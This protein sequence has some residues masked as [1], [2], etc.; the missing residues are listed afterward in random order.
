MENT[1]ALF[2][3]VLRREISALLLCLLGRELLG[4]KI[5][6]LLSTIVLHPAGKAAS[7]RTEAGTRFVSVPPAARRGAPRSCSPPAPASPALCSCLCSP[8]PFVQTPGTS[9]GLRDFL[10]CFNAARE[11]GT[12]KVTRFAWP[13][14]L[15][16][17]LVCLSAGCRG[18]VNLLGL[19]GV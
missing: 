3:G 18:C 15:L 4:R 1:R 8:W 19:E 14:C 11:S 13:Q 9:M 16:S 5:F 6:S 17:P 2:W 10:L 12:W 7:S